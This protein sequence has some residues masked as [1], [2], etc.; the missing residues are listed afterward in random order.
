MKKKNVGFSLI[1]LLIAVV[2]IGVIAAIAY[3]SYMAQILKSTRSD[4]KVAL[5]EAAQR[6]QRCFT[7]N[8][9]FKPAEGVCSVVDELTASGGA[10]SPEGYYVISLQNDEGYTS[11][12]YVIQAEPAAG[13]RQQQDDSCA[14]FT[15]NQAGVRYAEDSDGNVGTDNCWK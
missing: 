15:L 4:A 5:N 7:T 11:S 1:E 3:P 8:S 12:T 9:T 6:M 10:A 14:L 2:I 13:S